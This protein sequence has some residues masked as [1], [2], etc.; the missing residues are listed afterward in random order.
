MGAD[1]RKL[2]VANAVSVA[3]DGVTLAAGPL[4]AASVTHDP[5]LVAGAAFVQQLS[6][7]LFALLSGVVVDRVD[8]RRLIVIVDALRAV[9]VGGLAVSIFVGSAHLIALYAALFVLG[10][11]STLVDTAS[12]SLTPAIV[13]DDELTAANAGLQ[14]VQL[15]GGTLIAPPLGAYFFVLAAGLPFAFDAATF[16]LGAALIATIHRPQPTPSGPPGEKGI[17]REIATGIRWLLAHPGLRM[18]AVSICL[19]NITLE[20]VMAILVLY[21]RQRLGLGPVGFGLLLAATTVGGVIGTVVVST[22]TRRLGPSLLLR[23]GLLIECGTHLSLAL[24]RNPWV[25]GAT[26]VVFGIHAGVWGV[27]TVTLRQRAVPAEL[28]GRVNS[29]YFLFSVGG[30]ALGSLLG[31]V[32]ARQVGITTPFWVAAAAIA[33]L[34]VFAWRRFTPARLTATSEEATAPG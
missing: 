13:A 1:Y 23:I 30:G 25:A 31:G 19:M 14:G 4:L 3:G 12:I 7:L 22:L 20:S 5:L 16:V 26:L 34:A 10:V 18:L 29:V 11:G 27:V 17:R 28:R 6:W 9:A 2:W 32:L 33:V 15:V 8:P 21:A 24:T